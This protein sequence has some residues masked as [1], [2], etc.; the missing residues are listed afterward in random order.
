MHHVWRVGSVSF[1]A[2]GWGKVYICWDGVCSRLYAWVCYAFGTG[3]GNF[4]DYMSKAGNGWRSR[5]GGGKR[6]QGSF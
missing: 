2:C 4:S 5:P 6:D 1:K 3:G